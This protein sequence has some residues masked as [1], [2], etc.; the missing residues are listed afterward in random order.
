MLTG[1]RWD[2]SR[3]SEVH[4]L[5]FILSFDSLDE[6]EGVADMDSC[7][8]DSGDVEAAVA[9]AAFVCRAVCQETREVVGNALAKLSTLS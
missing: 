2:T 3:L 9:H 1:V 6:G 5:I 7:S 4:W 8:V